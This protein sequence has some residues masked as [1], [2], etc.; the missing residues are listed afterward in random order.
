MPIGQADFNPE[1]LLLVPEIKNRISVLGDLVAV[2][3][4]EHDGPAQ[5]YRYPGAQGEVGFIPALSQHFCN[6]CNRLRLTASG[7]LRPCLLSD[8]QENLKKV[9]RENGSDQDLA[10]VFITAVQHKPSDHNL[11]AKDPSPVCGQ[12]RAIGG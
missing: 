8:H 2:Q 4:A 6:K 3:E 1:S 7:Q 10:Q 5:R 9:L 11:V 12:M